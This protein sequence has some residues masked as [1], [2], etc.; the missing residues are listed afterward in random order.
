M[1]TTKSTSTTST[2]PRSNRALLGPCRQVFRKTYVVSWLSQFEPQF[3][4]IVD[5]F[6]IIKNS[7][8]K[9]KILSPFLGCS[10]NRLPLETQEF[11]SLGGMGITQ[12]KQLR[13]R[14]QPTL[15]QLVLPQRYQETK[16]KKKPSYNF[17][18]L[19]L[20]SV[21]CKMRLCHV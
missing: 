1:P 14:L 9:S 10:M 18:R 8:L 16:K 17:G 13:G 11:I 7:L 5:H 2:V 20:V 19:P 3:R 15:L 12:R 4:W 21:S 6:I